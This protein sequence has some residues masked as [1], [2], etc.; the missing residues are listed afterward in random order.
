MCVGVCFEMVHCMSQMI[1]KWHF[2]VC[3]L[4]TL[5]Q[6]VPTQACLLCTAKMVKM[7]GRKMFLEASISDINSEALYVESTTLFIN[8]KQKE[9]KAEPTK[10]PEKSER[11]S[12]PAGDIDAGPQDINQWHS[13]PRYANL[14]KGLGL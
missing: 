8:M 12:E 7:E 6:P 5:L 1:R 11:G 13:E 10:P 4:C 2:P 9:V 3:I 14:L